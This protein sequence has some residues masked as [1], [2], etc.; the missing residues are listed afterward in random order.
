MQELDIQAI[1]FVLV[2]RIR[3]ILAI[4]LAVAL[5]LGAYSQF[6]MPETYRSR[7]NM[8]VSNY[9]DR[10]DVAGTSSSSIAA[11]QAMVQ[12]Y[13]VV[14]QDDKIMDKVAANLKSRGYRMTNK[15][16]VNAVSLSSVDETAMLSVSAVTTDPK[17]SRAICLAIADEAPDLLQEVMKIGSIEVMA[18]AK[19]GE[20]VGPAVVRNTIVGALIGFFVCCAVVI[21]LYLLDNT[22][23]DEKNLKKRLNVIVLGTVPSFQLKG[24]GG[25]FRGKN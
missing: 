9:T 11:S 19:M 24:K 1:F 3:W 23:K 8:Y 6:F 7:F 25:R 22:V 14:L 15:Q 10:T 4:T 18:E 16:I 12:E 20:R 13:I 5:L 21:V 17:L 2:K